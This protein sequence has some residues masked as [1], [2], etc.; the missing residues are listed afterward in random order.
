[1]VHG[2]YLQYFFQVTLSTT[3]NSFLESAERGR[4][5]F[6][7]ISEVLSNFLMLV[8]NSFLHFSCSLVDISALAGTLEISCAQIMHQKKTNAQVNTTM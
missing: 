8:S 3:T 2:E 7:L 1:M 4:K 6:L 5:S